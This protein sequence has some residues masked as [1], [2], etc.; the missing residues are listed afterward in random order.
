MAQLTPE[1]RAVLE[2]QHYEVVGNH[3][4]V[5]ICTWAKKSLL[6]QDFC[7][8]Q[9]FYGIRSHLC[10]QMTPAVGFCDCKCVHCWR[11]HEYNQGIKMK[12]RL[13]SPKKILS[14]CIA[15]QRR[16]L[17]GFKGNKKINM[18]KLLEAQE[19]M[20]FAISLTGE[21]TLFPKLSELIKEIHALGKT[22]F[23]VTNGLHPKMLAEL[24]K[25]GALP[26]QLYVSISAPTKELYKKINIPLISGAWERLNETLEL[27]PSLD[28]R[29]VI[30]LTLIKGLND[31]NPTQYAKLIKKASPHFVEVKGYVWVGY[32]RKRLKKENMP[33]HKDVLA[34]SKQLAREL[35]WQII[36]QKKE[37]RVAL[38]AKKDYL[39][40]IMKF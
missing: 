21:P 25:K 1:V 5:E 2:R 19:P 26:T 27:L 10:C 33:Y 3:S 39:W 4:A 31:V 36:D 32:S 23:L 24:K 28:T 9:K 37:S 6:D 30:R 38:L 16:K 14:G 18:K 7:Y 17:S 22:T 40:R 29:K 12:G 35:G 20:N 34:F 15:A 8:K 11:A 13:D